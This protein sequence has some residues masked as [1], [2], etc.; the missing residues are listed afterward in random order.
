MRERLLLIAL[1]IGALVDG[2][3]AVFALFFQPL[4]GPLFDVPAKDAAMTTLLGGEF[5]VVALVYL[6]LLRDLERYR[7]LLWLV[8]LDQ[9][10]AIAL[11]AQEIAR[12]N[13]LG[14][15]KTIGPFPLNALLAA[16]FVWGALSTPD[17]AA[18]G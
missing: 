2:G 5:L 18:R 8:A 7:P 16:T 14:T 10:L 9:V 11:P 13:M 3:V 4:L 1:A 17:R 6:L 12:G 15:W